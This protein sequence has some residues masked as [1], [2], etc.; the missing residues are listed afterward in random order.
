MDPHSCPYTISELNLFSTVSTQLA[1]D[2]TSEV[3][4][5]PVA[6]FR[7]VEH[8]LNFMYP[9]LV[10]NYIDL[11]SIYLHVEAKIV[12]K[13]KTD[14]AADEKVAPVNYFLNTLFS[15]CSVSLND[16]QVI[17]QVNNPYCKILEALLFYS[18][19]A[20]ETFLTSALFFKHTAQHIDFIE[21]N[22]GMAKRF[23]IG[24]QNRLIDLVRWHHVDLSHQ[25]K[26]LIN[27]V[28]LRMKLERSKDNFALMA[29][30]DN[31]KVIIK[32]ASLKINKVDVSSSVQIGIEKA[33]QTGIIKI[34]FR[35]TDI[36]IFTLN[37]GIQSTNISNAVI[38]QLLYRITI[39]L[40]F[41]SAFSGNVKYNL[42]N[43]KNYNLNYICLLKDNQ[44]IP[45]KL[46]TP[47][48]TNKI[49]AKNFISLFEDI[50]CINHHKFT[51][52][53]YND[54]KDGYTL[55]CFDPTP[56]HSASESHIS[57]NQQGNISI[58]L[59][60]LTA[61]LE[62]VNIICLLEYNNT[63]EIDHSRTV[64]VDY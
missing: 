57:N 17:S 59:K 52:I 21:N 2:N 8:Q 7:I 20:Q 56:D 42:F 14:T 64:F 38:G 31:H 23:N 13:N 25:P 15:Q 47:D 37:S 4:V 61:I 62:T 36:K 11:N 53:S 44:M 30:N 5:H 49:Y 33:L 3:I 34:P 41:N 9:V 28:D 12:K 54:Y 55:Y 22:E 18:K 32:N 40:V 51:N 19:E 26:L 48:Y 10:K 45:P 60:F 6:T 58:K 24:K 29:N 43:F 39:G 50:G 1:I 46:Y 63:L 27:N 35:R 16:K